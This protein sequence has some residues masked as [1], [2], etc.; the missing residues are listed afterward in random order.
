[1]FLTLCFRQRT[2]TTDIANVNAIVQK[3][4]FSE[5]KSDLIIAQL[6][7][8]HSFCRQAGKQAGGGSTVVYVR[9]CLQPKV[10]IL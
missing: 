8:L 6:Q 3:M 1:M 7:L 9:F 2:V 10:F 4:L 5:H